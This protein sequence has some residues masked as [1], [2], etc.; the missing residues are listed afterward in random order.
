[1]PDP[2]L[3]VI[4][5]TLNRHAFLKRALAC[6]LKTDYP[7]FEIIVMDQGR[8]PA[9]AQGDFADPRL[10]VQRLGRRSLPHAR[11]AGLAAVRGDIVLFLDDDITFAP[12]LF[13]CHVDAHLKHPAAGAVTGKITLKPPHFWP[14]QDAVVA[15]DPHTAKLSVNY[16][17]D[18][19]G[20]VDFHSGANV[21]FKKA[22]FASAG[23]F[24]ENFLGNAVYEEIDFGLRLRQKG[25]T[26]Y[27]EP[28]AAIVHFR[29][30]AGGCRNDQASH[31]HFLKFYNTA[32]FFFKN[33][34]TLFPF[35][36]LKA[37]KDEI[38][39]ITRT[40]RGHDW[41]R[42]FYYLSGIW[43]GALRG[44]VKKFLRI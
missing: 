20:F 36:F 27:Y 26:V 4:I 38:E 1:M 13:R 12:D 33:F 42:A 40:G 5:P 31:Y 25:Y 7:A 30:D 37:M 15:L 24:D 41:T 32:Y 44:S 6:A 22:V 8:T 34:F 10:R 39:F 19:A 28:A 9:L 23:R 16:A 35:R 14:A 18:R 17:K 3:S 43:A 11:N 29:A 2:F 21:S